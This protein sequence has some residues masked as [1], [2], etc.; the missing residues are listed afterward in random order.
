MNPDTDT[1][2]VFP[3]RQLKIAVLDARRDTLFRFTV[4]KLSLFRL[5]Y[6]GGVGTQPETQEK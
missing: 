1:A 6:T 3:L 2:T 4:Q 5:R